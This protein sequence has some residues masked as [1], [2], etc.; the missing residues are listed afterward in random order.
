M[1]TPLKKRYAVRY[2]I[3]DDFGSLLWEGNASVVSDEMPLDD[4]PRVVAVWHAITAEN[5]RRD[6]DQMGGVPAGRVVITALREA[7]R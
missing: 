2:L 4:G 7:Q 5:I 6:C 1:T 3:V